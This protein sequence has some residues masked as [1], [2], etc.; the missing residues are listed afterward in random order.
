MSFAGTLN[1]RISELDE[2]INSKAAPFFKN[3]AKDKK[4]LLLDI[5]EL[6]RNQ[7]VYTPTENGLP[8][9]VK[10]ES[11]LFNFE[12]RSSLDDYPKEIVVYRDNN[13]NVDS[14]RYLLACGD[15][16]DW[17]HNADLSVII[18]YVFSQFGLFSRKEAE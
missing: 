13:G 16:T 11:V 18:D 17:S 6:F 12:V 10:L 14:Y 15:I 4:A 7:L 2:I 9:N 1:A 3:V 5:L 8:R